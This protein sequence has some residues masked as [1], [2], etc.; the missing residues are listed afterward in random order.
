MHVVLSCMHVVLSWLNLIS[1]LLTT[2]AFSFGGVVCLPKQTKC[3]INWS[4]AAAVEIEQYR[5]STKE[6][7]KK[8]G[9]L[10]AM[11]CDNCNCASVE[12]QWQIDQF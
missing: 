12:H 6:L 7:L 5:T 9:V 2:C 1:W 10:P 8:T 4:K 3:T 11:T